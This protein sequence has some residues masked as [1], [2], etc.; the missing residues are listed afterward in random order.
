MNIARLMLGLALTCIFS[1]VGF[2]CILPVIR[3]VLHPG[4]SPS[5]PLTSSEIVIAIS[6]TCFLTILLSG[7]FGTLIVGP[8]SYK[9]SA[10]WIVGLCTFMEMLILTGVVG[11][12]VGGS[13]PGLRVGSGITFAVG[14]IATG[15]FV[16]LA[17]CFI[18]RRVYKH[19]VED[20]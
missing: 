19:R 4:A 1:L 16:Y 20:V 11:I 15:A 3:H 13:N 8:Q 10:A 14:M 12:A 2:A 6:L 18:L 9:R 7:I 17:V 5:N